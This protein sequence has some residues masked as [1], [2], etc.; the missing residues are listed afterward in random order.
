MTCAHCG[1]DFH[2]A[3]MRGRPKHC[4]ER[5][6]RAAQNA[7]RGH[8]PPGTRARRQPRSEP[9]TRAPRQP[10]QRKAGTQRWLTDPTVRV[11]PE[12]NCFFDAGTCRHRR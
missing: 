3:T 2:P 9:A 8:A 11:C 12:D 10:R 4:S 1:A 5:C 6:R 7:R